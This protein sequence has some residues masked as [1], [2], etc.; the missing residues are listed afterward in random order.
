MCMALLGM[1]QFPFTKLLYMR[2]GSIMHELVSSCG[3][4]SRFP[5]PPSFHIVTS[6]TLN[7]SFAG[8]LYWRWVRYRG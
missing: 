4:Q 3:G 1:W 6:R 2:A 7:E 8:D 5:T